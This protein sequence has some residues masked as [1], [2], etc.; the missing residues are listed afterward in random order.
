MVIADV[1][2]FLTARTINVDKVI[3]MA[4]VH[5]GKFEDLMIDLE[6]GSV[7][8]AVLSFGGFLSLG[9]KL[10]AVP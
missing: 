5:L 1:P 8:Y 10:F 2:L 6:N 7:T 4:G 3:N 9:N